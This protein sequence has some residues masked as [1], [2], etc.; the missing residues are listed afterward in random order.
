MYIFE[1]KPALPI[2]EGIALWM[3]GSAGPAELI[4]AMNPS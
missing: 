3:V 1:E 2:N 4:L